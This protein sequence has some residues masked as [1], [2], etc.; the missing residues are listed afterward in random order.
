MPSDNDTMAVQLHEFVSCHGLGL[1]L[2]TVVQEEQP[3]L[4]YLKESWML[5]LLCF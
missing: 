2:C 1:S 5:I 3:K 4:A